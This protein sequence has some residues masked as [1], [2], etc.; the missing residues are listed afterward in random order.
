M[1][2]PPGPLSS[3][4]YLTDHLGQAPRAMFVISSVLNFFSLAIYCLH[5]PSQYNDT[6]A[7][8][9]ACGGYLKDV[10]TYLVLSIRLVQD[11]YILY[12]P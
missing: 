5:L 2:I 7:Y 11:L 1:I 12:E 3:S 10:D 6:V 9:K 4:M 8:M